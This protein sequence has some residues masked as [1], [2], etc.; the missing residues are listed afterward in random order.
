VLVR[1]GKEITYN[2]QLHALTIKSDF[3]AIALSNQITTQYLIYQEQDSGPPE[4]E[5]ED[6]DKL[7]PFPGSG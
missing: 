5:E 3:L 4:L 2:E 6:S 1:L 7:P